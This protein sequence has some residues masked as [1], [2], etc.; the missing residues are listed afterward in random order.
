MTRAALLLAT[1]LCAACSRPDNASGAGGVSAGEARA[2]D[3]A[4]EMVQSQQLPV[5][6]IPSPQVPIPAQQPAAKSPSPNPA[7]P[8]G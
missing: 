1:L 7:K 2:L 4:A 3:D 8:A 6:A 5:S